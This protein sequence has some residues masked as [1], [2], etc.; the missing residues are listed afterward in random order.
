LEIMREDLANQQNQTST[1]GK[2]SV[3][4]NSA[5]KATPAKAKAKAKP[6]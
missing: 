2:K 6:K 5:K 1:A 4:P 3:K